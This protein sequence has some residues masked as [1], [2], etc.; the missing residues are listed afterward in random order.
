MLYSI[1][2]NCNLYFRN[3]SIVL[4]THFIDVKFLYRQNG[5]GAKQ[6]SNLLLSKRIITRNGRAGHAGQLLNEN[7]KQWKLGGLGGGRTQDRDG[8]VDYNN[9]GLGGAE[10]FFWQDAWSMCFAIGEELE[11]LLFV[12]YTKEST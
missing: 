6:K 8:T 1:L 10:L 2:E 3:L 9:G 4:H 7:G 12:K 5:L 11:Y